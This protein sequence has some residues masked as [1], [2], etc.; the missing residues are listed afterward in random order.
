M[1]EAT[2]FLLALRE[3]VLFYWHHTSY[4]GIVIRSFCAAAG[5][6]YSA[7]Q[8]IVRYEIGI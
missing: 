2:Y 8:C 5:F 6:W 3:F 1:N 4:H 7:Q